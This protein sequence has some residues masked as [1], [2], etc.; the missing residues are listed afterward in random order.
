MMKARYVQPCTDLRPPDLTKTCPG[1]LLQQGEIPH[2]L[3][4][5]EDLITEFLL[6][7]HPVNQRKLP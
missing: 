1:C 3:P 5:S 4:Q 6:P 7:I 2:H